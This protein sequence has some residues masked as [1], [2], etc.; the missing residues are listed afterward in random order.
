MCSRWL[1][2]GM[3]VAGCVFL[4]AG[5]RLF[6]LIYCGPPGKEL[7]PPAER[8]VQPPEKNQGGT[9]PMSSA[10]GAGEAVEI[11]GTPAPDPTPPVFTI[12]TFQ[13]PMAVVGVEYR[14]SLEA[15]GVRGPAIWTVVEGGL[16]PGL[17]LSPDGVISGIPEEAGEWRF[18]VRLAARSGQL[19]RKA[20]RLLVREDREVSEEGVRIITETIPGGYLGRNYLQQLA[21]EGGAPPYQWDWE[22][23]TLPEGIRFNRDSG[24]IFGIPRERGDFEFFISVADREEDFSEREYTLRIGESGVE[25]VTAALPPAVKDERYSLTLRARGGVVPYTWRLLAGQLPEGLE[26]DRD[27]GIISG[28]PVRWE[29]AEFTVRVADREGNAAVREFQLAMG[30]A[31]YGGLRIVTGSLPHASRGEVYAV[32]LEAD[33]GEEPYVWTVSDGDLPPSLYLDAESGEIGGLPERVGKSNFT[34][35]VSDR[36][37]RTARQEF[38]LIVDHQLV[39]ITTGSL[40]PAT[41]GEEYQHLLGATGGSPPYFFTLESGRLPSGLSLTGISGLIEGIVSDMYFRQGDQE[42][43]FRVKVADREDQVDIA[44]L[45]L[46]VF[47][48]LD[49]LAPAAGGPAPTPRPIPTL[50]P[51]GPADAISELIGAVSDSKVGLAWRNPPGEDF[52]RI[53][54]LRKTDGYPQD[55]EDG[56]VV[57]SGRGDNFVDYRG[58]ENRR[59]YFY[60]VIPYNRDGSFPGINQDNRIALTPQ[61]VGISGA[62]DPYADEVVGFQPLSSTARSPSVVLGPPSGQTLFLQARSNDDGGASS[63]YGG[64]ITLK[65]ADNMAVNEA[66]DDFTVF[67][68]VPMIRLERLPSAVRWMRPAIVAVSQDGESWREFPFNFRTGYLEDE[69]INYYSPFAYQYGF[70]GITPT[71]S[72]NFYPDPTNPA[73]SG[74]DSFDLDDLPGRPFTWIQYL[75]ITATGDRWLSGENGSPVRHTDYRNSLS[76]EDG[77]GFELDAVSAVN[78]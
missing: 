19:T 71:E 74:G 3:L 18:T 34:V 45:T 62:N 60:A 49:P 69:G 28:I 67:G 5:A 70:A 17:N 76:G 51:S 75:R 50:T 54:I 57:Y 2:I 72:R 11:S 1:R 36:P 47:D 32:R 25:I 8:S 29:T 23:G 31:E 39:Y 56:T 4:A 20:L 42:F 66:G 35:M 58:L 7:V 46:E 77:S 40:P 52:D 22:G 38:S 41:A 78:Y 53:R 6:Y 68:N 63:P 10:R 16:P 24:V 61:A 21:A 44:E 59:T 37:G 12:R 9:R 13:L 30:V 64:T 55:E 27:R 14:Q 26:F 73:V 15:G 33:A 48:P 65:F 43:G